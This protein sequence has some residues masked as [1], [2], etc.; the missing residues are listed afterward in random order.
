MVHSDLHA[1]LF[2]S[3]CTGEKFIPVPRTGNPV[4][5]IV[6]PL[7]SEFPIRMRVP[8]FSPQLIRRWRN[9]RYG[10]VDHFWPCLCSARALPT[11]IPYWNALVSWPGVSDFAKSFLNFCTAIRSWR[12]CEKCINRDLLIS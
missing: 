6:L 12:V 1:H 4:K 11:A 10:D 2:D 9:N 3:F 5:Q 7:L 8:V